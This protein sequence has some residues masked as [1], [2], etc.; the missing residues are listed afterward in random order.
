MS[1][2]KSD[3][4]TIQ[5]SWVSAFMD[6]E[7]DLTQQTRWNETVHE[8][9]YYYTVTRQVL[10]GETTRGRDAGYQTERTTWMA[11]WARIDAG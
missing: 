9:L 5:E 7:A 8:Q 11:F 3:N 6:G 10:R 1:P 4:L 2:L